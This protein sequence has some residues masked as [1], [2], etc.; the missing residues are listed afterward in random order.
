MAH[1][2]NNPRKILISPSI[3]AADYGRIAEEIKAVEEA[4]AD[5]LHL[6][7][8]DGHFVPNLTIGPDFIKAVRKYTHL[9]LDAHLMISNPLDYLK[10]YAEVGADMLVVHVETIDHPQK[11]ID[12][13]HARGIKAGLVI[14]PETPFD[15]PAE[16]FAD[17]D[18]FLVMSV[19]PG[20]YGQQFI[21]DVLP[22]VE[23]IRRIIDNGGYA[24]RLQIDGGINIVT[25]RQA[26]AAGADVLV[27]GSAVFNAPDYANAITVLRG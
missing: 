2:Q 14:N 25:A 12:E 26:I 24:T 7:I 1:T 23:T 13:I 11:V 5:W 8:M 18:L 21:A 22:K 17:L 3:I 6:D 20:F 4:G 15:L 16:I 19:H 10:T 9:F 27:A